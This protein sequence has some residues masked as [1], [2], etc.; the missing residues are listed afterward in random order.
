MI[1]F[2]E[3]NNKTL[4]NLQCLQNAIPLIFLKR[5][6]ACL[7]VKPETKSTIN[8]NMEYVL[9]DCCESSHRISSGS[10]N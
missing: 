1:A 5:L 7:S 9:P 6:N 3:N 8:R 2:S 4:K 10:I